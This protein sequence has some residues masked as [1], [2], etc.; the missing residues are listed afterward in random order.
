MANATLAEVKMLPAHANQPVRYEA[1]LAY[2]FGASSLAQKYWPPAL[3]MA[4]ESS[5]SE[6]PT[7][8]ARGSQ[9]LKVIES[10]G[11]QKGRD[12]SDLSSSPTSLVYER[13]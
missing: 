11:T 4:E 9:H 3:G 6:I 8:R 7:P 1:K 2:L 5:D 13:E 10:N 12:H